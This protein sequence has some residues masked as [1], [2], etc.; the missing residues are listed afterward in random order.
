MASK[1]SV[2]KCKDLM[3]FSSDADDKSHSGQQQLHSAREQDSFEL[4]IAT[5]EIVQI[6]RL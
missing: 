5:D 1:I 6:V 4:S 2:F 3:E